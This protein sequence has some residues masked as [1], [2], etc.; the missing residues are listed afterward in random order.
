MYNRMTGEGIPRGALKSSLLDPV[1]DVA[2]APG[3]TVVDQVDLV[4]TTEPVP[5]WFAPAL[6]AALTDPAL[7]AELPPG[8]SMTVEDYLAMPTSLRTALI[9]SLVAAYAGYLIA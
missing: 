7:G 9:S 6:E 5:A 4:E 2:S 1:V 8:E 3:V